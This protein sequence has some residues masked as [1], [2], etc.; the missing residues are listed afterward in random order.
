MAREFTTI[1]YRVWLREPCEHSITH[2]CSTFGATVQ[3]SGQK[4]PTFQVIYQ[5][6]LWCRTWLGQRTLE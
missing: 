4:V 6:W 1:E 3:H 2:G 5:L